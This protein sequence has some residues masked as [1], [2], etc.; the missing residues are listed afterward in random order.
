[1]KRK[2]YILLSAALLI[3]F[4]SCDKSRNNPELVKE[5][6]KIDFVT[7]PFHESFI[8]ANQ[9]RG[10]ET[11]NDDMQNFGIYA[12]YTTDAFT[13]GTS[14]PNFMCNT[15]VQKANEQWTYAPLMYWPSSGNLSF[16][17]Y[18]PYAEANDLYSALTS[19]NTT[20]GYP[21]LTYTVPDAIITQRDLLVSLPLIDQTKANTNSNGKLPLTFKHALSSIV[22]KAKMSSSC[23]FPV[24]VTSITLGDFKHKATLS[25]VNSPEIFSWT[26]TQDAEDKSYTLSTNNTDP[27]LEDTDLSKITNEY[28]SITSTTSHLMLLPQEIDA[29]DEIQVSVEYRFAAESIQTRTITVSLKQIINSLESGKRYSINILVSALANITLTCTVAPWIP[30]TVNVPEF[31]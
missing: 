16:F 10:S 7:T 28:T 25:Y 27:G 23:D 8:Q 4:T 18:S 19:T 22:F 14:S 3:A 9:A 21:R 15:R 1:M 6:D 26:T 12:Y 11:G 24:R 13:P 30:E 29:S 17:A 20:S 31:K 5:N 2:E